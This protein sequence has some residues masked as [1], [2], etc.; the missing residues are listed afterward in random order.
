MEVERMADIQTEIELL[1]NEI[2]K[3]NAV[4]SKAIT[5]RR[6]IGK[7]SQLA[8]EANIAVAAARQALAAV[9]IKLRTLYESKTD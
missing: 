4:I 7:D 2:Q 3:A 5:N 6:A 8:A 9:E 1:Q